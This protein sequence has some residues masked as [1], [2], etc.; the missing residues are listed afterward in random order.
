MLGCFAAKALIY[1]CIGFEIG[2]FFLP[3]KHGYGSLQST[4]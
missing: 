2:T 3:L 1:G 4:Y